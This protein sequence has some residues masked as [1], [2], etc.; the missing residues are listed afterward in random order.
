[1]FKSERIE[2]L[3]ASLIGFQAEVEGVRKT[4]ENPFFHSKYADLAECWETI[5]MPLTSNGLCVVQST[6]I[7][8]SGGLILETMLIH[9]SG[10]YI[11]GRLRMN[12]E[13]P[14]S[15]Q[16]MGSCVTYARRY[17]LMSL[18]GLSPTDDD[19]NAASVVPAGLI[20]DWDGKDWHTC[21]NHLNKDNNAQPLGQ[22]SQVGMKWLL[23]EWNPGSSKEDL[24][25]SRALRKYS[26]EAEVNQEEETK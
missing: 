7:D 11:G 23:T 22:V 18:L 20:A 8:E 25:L 24:Q 12:P 13:K 4:S 14:N 9:T 16:A 1:M 6:D 5:R 2:N 19:G 10:E 26:E 15:P 17:G 3:A 21:P